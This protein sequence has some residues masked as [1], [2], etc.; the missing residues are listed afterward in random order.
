MRDLDPAGRGTAFPLGYGDP[1]E[2]LQARMDYL[3]R[4]HTALDLMRKGE[5]F[6]VG[7]YYAHISRLPDAGRL[8]KEWYQ[9]MPSGGPGIDREELLQWLGL[10]RR[11]SLEQILAL[12]PAGMRDTWDELDQMATEGMLQ[13][14]HVEMGKG[15]LETVALT[16][17]GWKKM[18][19]T[20]E[21][22]KAWGWGPRRPLPQ[23]REF[24]EQV[25]GDAVS[26]ALHELDTM[27]AKPIGVLL[28]PALRRLYLGAPYVPD[29]RLDF[30][31]RLGVPGHYLMEVEG[32]GS[33]Y[34]GR[35]HRE[36]MDSAGMFRAF[37]TRGAT[38]GGGGG[39]VSITR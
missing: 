18:L 32:R 38:A 5:A 37:S 6:S 12:A 3:A 29:L 36:K 9:K 24:H 22:A 11:P 25:V 19:E 7:G 20:H 4:R 27:T 21:D 1:N 34:R 17:K 15:R 10:Y 26:Y 16:P 14:S 39:R 2:G 28:D 31:D 33:D 23:N 30:E 8:L 13:M 35:G